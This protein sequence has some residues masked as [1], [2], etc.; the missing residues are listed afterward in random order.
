VSLFNSSHFSPNNRMADMSD[1]MVGAVTNWNGFMI[2]TR[3]AFYNMGPQ[4]R[5]PVHELGAKVS[6]NLISLWDENESLKP[7]GLRPF[8]GVYG[9]Y[10]TDQDTVQLFANVGVE[11]TWRFDLKGTKVGLS[12]PI[13]WGLGGNGY[14]FNSDGS[15]APCGYFGSSLTASIALPVP[16]QYGQWFLNTSVQYL[17]LSAYSTQTAGED[18]NDVCIGKIGL[19]FVY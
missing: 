18:R 14:Y 8:V 6:Y 1:V 4:M 10:I 7:F 3:Y 13:D 11:P 19:S 12:L 5:T 16:E 2:D 15:N 17:H 9:D